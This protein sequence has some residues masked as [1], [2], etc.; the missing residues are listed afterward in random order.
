M[1][2]LKLKE[3][4][5]PFTPDDTLIVLSALKH[6]LFNFVKSPSDI[7]LFYFKIY[8]LASV[9]VSPSSLKLKI[10]FLIQFD[11]GRCKVNNVTTSLRNWHISHPT[12]SHDEL[13]LPRRKEDNFLQFDVV[14]GLGRGGWEW[15]K[16]A[17]LTA[18][19]NTVHS[20]VFPA[21]QS[22]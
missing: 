20:E 6:K 16:T 1:C 9:Y 10:R 3:N 5:I 21:S 17:S 15:W 14:T 7:V 8:H 12:S 18:D 22:F 19:T 11:L 4:S 2:N 13:S